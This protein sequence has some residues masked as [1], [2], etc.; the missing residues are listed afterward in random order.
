[1]TKQRCYQCNLGKPN[2]LP[3]ET[4]ISD[5]AIVACDHPSFIVW[6]WREAREF[7]RELNLRALSRN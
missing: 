5:G 2:G 4:F 3:E 7:W 1:M 6:L